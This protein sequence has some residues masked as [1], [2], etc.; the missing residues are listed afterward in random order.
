MNGTA[1]VITFSE[2]LAA[3][4]S[5][6]NTAFTVKKTPSG[7]SQ[8]TLTL[9]STAPSISGSTVTLALATASSVASSDTNVLV[10]HTKPATG[11]ANKLVDRFGNETAAFTDQGVDNELADS[12]DPELSATSPAVLAAGGLTLTLTYSEALKTTSVPD[13]AV[14]TVKATPMGGNEAEA[15]LAASNAVAVTDS[16]V[17]LK[18][19]T[20]IAHNDGSVKVSYAKPASGSVIEDAAGNAAPAFSDQA[21]TNN[22]LAPRVSIEALHT[23]ASSLIAHPVLRLTRSNTGTADLPVALDVTQSDPYV[24]PPQDTYTIQAGDTS[25]DV[26]I[27]LDYPDNTSGDLTYTVDPSDD[28]APAL[29]PNNAATTQV[30]APASGMPLSIRHDQTM[31]T[32]NEGASLN[33]TLTFTLAPGLAEPRDSYAVYLDV[34]AEDASP[35]ADFVGFT[36]PEPRAVAEPGDWQ[37]AGGGMTQTVTI[38]VETIGDSEVEANET[39]YLFF[40]AG[41]IDDSLN[42]PSTDLDNRT[43][44]SILDDDPLV[45]TGVEVTSTPGGG[46]YGV[47]DKIEFTVTF[48]AYVTV[49]GATQFEFQLGG[50]TPQAAGLESDEEMEA[51]FEYTVAAGDGDDDGISW[52]A[53]VLSLNGGSIIASAK[54]ALIPRN[55]NLDHAAQVALPGHKVDT[56][57]PSLA[58]AAAEGT[59]LTLTFSEEL[60]ATAPAASAFTVKV[61]GSSG[62]SPTGV[63]VSGSAVILTLGTAVEPGQTVTVSYAKPTTNKVRDLSG[64]EADIFTDEDVATVP[65]VEVTVTFADTSYTVAEGEIVDVVVRLSADPQRTVVIPLTAWTRATHPPPTTPCPPT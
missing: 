64:I 10:S 26:K 60:N 40:A 4:A 28:Y 45:V 56:I 43:T 55:A 25:R 36:D 51:T 5:L 9:S 29:A 62:T 48:G 54:E 15:D 42:I 46:Y 18:L 41:S 16:T 12:M 3:A 63:S 8:T 35:G 50:A 31:W 11:T 39:F 52:G 59:A 20:P 58:G 37:T 21:V 57:K 23:D 44:V 49:E 1:L 27:S 33:V 13:R 38:S 7:G 32:V 34:E 65:P 47:D 30:K 6:A 2:P 53:N 19:A 61:D 22:S 14:F 24:D 17:V